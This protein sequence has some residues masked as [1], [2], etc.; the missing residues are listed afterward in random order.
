M[1]IPESVQ[2][3]GD[4]PPD[5]KAPLGP[6]A[7]VIDQIHAIEPKVDFRDPSWGSFEGDGFSI[8]FNMGKEAVC[9][10]IMLHVRGGGDAM[11]FIDK[12][13]S[14]MKLRGIDC[15]SGD[16]FSLDGSVKTFGDWRGFRERVASSTIESAPAG[17][18]TAKRPSGSESTAVFYILMVILLIFALLRLLRGKLGALR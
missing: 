10:G 1:R 16:F 2:K 18:A 17:A 14:T 5:Y 15:Q 13:L 12:L 3:A 11:V 4:L 9:D 7:S 8:E 6:R